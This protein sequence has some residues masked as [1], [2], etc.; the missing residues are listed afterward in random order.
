MTQRTLRKLAMLLPWIS[1]SRLARPDCGAGAAGAGGGAGAPGA[2]GGGGAAVRSAPKPRSARRK[3]T[4]ATPSVTDQ[5][6][7]RD[8][9][10][11][12]AALYTGRN[13]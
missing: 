11:V 10:A 1:A 13:T 6:V 2:G 8:D 5:V 7:H 4:S 12:A 9:Q 3:L